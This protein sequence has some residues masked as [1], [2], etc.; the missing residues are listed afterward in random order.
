MMKTRSL[1][2][3]DQTAMTDVLPF[4]PYI[5]GPKMDWT[6]IDGL[7]HRFLTWKLK[8]EHILDCELASLSE[9]RQCKKA[10]LMGR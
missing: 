8:C 9:S 7:Y 2:K 6:V 10:D 3:N 1:C 5:E 4:V